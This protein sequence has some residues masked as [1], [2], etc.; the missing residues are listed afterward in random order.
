MLLGVQS[1]NAMTFTL[2]T[3]SDPTG[4]EGCAA[5]MDGKT[6]TKWGSWEGWYGSNPWAVFKA[7]L[8][9]AVANYELVIANDTPSSPGRN[10][11]KW[12]VY[13]G[14]FSSDADATK[15]AEG[16][17]LLDEKEENVPTGESNNSYLA[18]PYT[19]SKA[20]TD[21]YAYF[22]I[23]VDA[24]A[25]GW[26]EYCQMGEFRFVNEVVD[27]SGAQ[28]YL[29]YEPTG[30]DEDLITAYN[31]KKAELLVAYSSADIDAI[32]TLSGEIAQLKAKIE[33]IKNGGFI[34]LTGSSCWSDGHYSQ[35]VDGKENTKWGGN[36]SGNVGD[37]EH[38]QYVVFRG[39]AQQPF[40][41]KLVTGGDTQRYYIR[42]WKT[43]KVF[44]GNFAS[45]AEATKDAAGW[46]V[47]DEREDIST[48][49]LPNK[50][51]YLATLNFT[52]GVTAAYSYYK[53]E[54]YA[55]GG[56][57]QQMSE[58]Y[59]CSEEE[60]NA[61]RQSQI[62]NLAEF[63]AGLD[64]MVVLPEDEANKATFAEKY[65]ELKTT[66]NADV[67]TLLYNELS[68]LKEIIEESSAFATGG[69]RALSGNTAWGD[70]EN[71]TKLVDGDTTTKWGGS[72][73]SEGS[74]VIFKQ[75]VAGQYNVYKLVTGNDTKSSPGR[76]WKKWKIYGASPKLVS[77]T[78]EAEQVT[79]DLS[80]WTLLDQKEDIGQD[81]LPGDNFT[82]A[83]FS[84]SEAW[85]KSYKYF[86]IEVEEAY[87]GSSIQMSEF[88]ML[89]DEEWEAE[90]QA[91]IDDLM[92]RASVLATSLGD[93]VIP[94]TL[95]NKILTESQALA[96]AV[97]TA[98]PEQLLSAYNAALQYMADA[99]ALIADY[100]LV[101]VE[102]VYQ[103]ATAKQLVTFAGLVNGGVNDAQAVVTADLDLADVITTETPWAAIGT[104]DAPFKGTFDG[105]GHAFTNFEGT[106]D[107]AVGKYGLFG[108][109]ESATVK[110]FSIDGNLTVP[111][112]ASNGSGVIGWAVSSTISNIY[113]TLVIEVGGDGAK[114]VGGIVGSAQGGVNTIS[115]CTFAGSLT[116]AAGSHDC[117]AGIAGYMSSDKIL[118]C[119]NF[120]TIDYYTNNCYA[121]GITGYINNA[122][123]TVA[124]CL[125]VGTVT[126]KGDGTS[127]YGGAFVGRL[128]KDAA[129]I[130]NNYWL[131]GSAEKSSGEK[132]LA[133]PA[134]TEVTAEQ[135]ASGE[136]AY[137]LNLEQTEDVNWYQ[138]LFYKEII[139]EQY[140]VTIGSTTQEP[141]VT[142]VILAGN[143][144]TYTFTLPDFS[145]TTMSQTV[146]VGDMSLEGI[147]INADGTF[148]K[149]G[150]FDVPDDKIPAALASYASF[151]KN[152][153]Y[154]LNGKVNDTKLYA[155]IDITVT[156][157]GMTANVVAG[158][159][160]FEPVAPALTGDNYPV[161]DATHGIVYPAGQ[162]HCDGTP[163]AAFE[164]YSNNPAALIQDS[165]DFVDGIC[166]YCGIVDETYMTPNADGFF[167]I[168]DGKQL[169]WFAGYV[170][171][172][173]PAA[174]GLLVADIDL[175][176]VIADESLKFSIGTNAVPFTGVF[177]GQR[178]A[179][180]NITY[181]AT[182]QYN[183][184]F[185][186]IADGAV[187][188]DFDAYGTMTI[189]SSV[190]GRA[191]AL[192]AAATGSDVLISG[193]FSNI[194]YNNQLAGAQVGGILGG[195][196]NGNITVDRCTYSGTLDGNDAGGGGNYGGI[197]GYVNNNGSAYLTVSNCLF[198]GELKNSASTT[199]GCTFGGIVGY[200]GA[201]PTA[202]IKNC[203]SIG[204]VNSNVNGQFF[205]AV[206]S[207]KCSIKNSYYQGANVNGSASTVTLTTQ[208]ATL[209]TDDQL[210]SG[211]VAAK[212]APAFRQMIGSA[213]PTLNTDLPVVAEITS[214]GYATL[215]QEETDL[216]IPAGV[217]VFAG[218]K[219]DNWLLL[220]AIEG[221]FAA[222]EPV[223]LKGEAGFYMFLP[224]T[225]ATKAAANDLKGTAEGIEAD[226]NMYILA[227]P[228][229][230]ETGFYRATPGTTITRGKAYLEDVSGVKAFIFDEDGATG[231]AEVETAVENGAIYNVAGQRLQK[232]QK[233]INIV[234]NKKVLK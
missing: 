9:I 206:K 147:E 135:L 5:L 6:E 138:T 176:D 80:S 27:T 134:A 72:M 76:N 228:A 184:L 90:R 162:L 86:K 221:K 110:N 78:P 94:A 69:Y 233:G 82:S 220:N 226:G 161:L 163:Y 45:E 7:A 209:V 193:I 129:N 167:E 46:V 194:S 131:A 219:S 101:P 156:L 232:M 14:N 67:L 217:E 172:A 152:I 108:N 174:N 41:Y 170:K 58:I 178:H 114:H 127:T 207:G 48:D 190:T 112:G 195:S 97:T 123:P 16:W 204:I 188:K 103:I 222:S 104:T 49:Y 53:I 109:I 171:Q 42:N 214:A 77:G 29:D 96:L 157:L 24:L 11:K 62:D 185:G 145:L 223:V 136:I 154:T 70:G 227:Q 224:T 192:I 231:I 38:V 87:S 91:Y 144:K 71:W 216:E 111:A 37:A 132:V 155:T 55:S 102:G 139:A 36:F 47:L 100:A 118:N 28:E 142:D 18:V 26:E 150:T 146:Y 218:V 95:Q 2:V 85:A 128:R 1:V 189:S 210:A 23:I 66:T 126:Y 140:V 169:Q 175:F 21:S 164:A 187:V 89:T 153:P 44:G 197:V 59:L 199:A 121:G 198:D 141:K 4:V 105:Q 122:N 225:D 57:Q 213:Y 196:L 52:N 40:F 25:G 203:L 75:N 166:T 93:V 17:V 54:V 116:V 84:F 179:I 39:A 160:D 81:L 230:E 173:D 124:N 113:S 106:T 181:T 73:P 20:T 92:I 22:M 177:D 60:F 56:T 211:F 83:F 208:Q 64:E 43:W 115:N 8:P 186:K 33:T 200:V 205:G 202:T 99:P 229:G 30:V 12:R 143:G 191:V 98:T 107:V 149:T 15:D 165:H 183:G 65:E 182:G 74:Y 180:S 119:A 215:Y 158:V 212:L 151:L 19:L 168:A 133:A 35:L 68:A 61:I 159:D 88:R 50:N 130:K 32:I 3:G 10:W 63:A 117:F 34:A 137:K 31:A 234:G 51:N 125:N 120:G 13:G 201:S 148:S 79:R